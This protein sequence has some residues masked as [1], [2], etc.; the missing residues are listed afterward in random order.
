ME[1]TALRKRRDQGEAKNTRIHTIDTIT[2]PSRRL[3][4]FVPQIILLQ[5]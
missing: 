3:I 2:P 4:F 1:N 5:S